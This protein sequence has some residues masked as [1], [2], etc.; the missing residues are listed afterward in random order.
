MSYK[1]TNLAH[2][3][4][5]SKHPISSVKNNKYPTS[6]PSPKNSSRKY[7]NN[8]QSPLKEDELDLIRRKFLNKSKNLK[9]SSSY[10]SFASP[11]NHFNLNK[12]PKLNNTIKSQLILTS[13]DNN[14]SI[15]YSKDKMYSYMNNSHYNSNNK[16]NS[17]NKSMNN[18]SIS[19]SVKKKKMSKENHTHSNASLKVNSNYQKKQFAFT[20]ISSRKNST[21]N[22]KVKN[23]KEN[24]QFL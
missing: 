5:L 1:I 15:I 7:S 4:S 8:H 11:M 16:N 21:N 12:Q 9:Y 24:K 23:E 20:A 10:L 6:I 22:I 19:I 2:F 3:T 13:M 17:M 14:S 18:K